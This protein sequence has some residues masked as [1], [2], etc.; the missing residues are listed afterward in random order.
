M[1]N[2]WKKKDEHDVIGGRFNVVRT[3]GEGGFGKVKLA[4]DTDNNNNEV[5]IKLMKPEKY[6][7]AQEK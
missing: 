4:Y 3:L 6:E 5:A 2:F 1:F 7:S